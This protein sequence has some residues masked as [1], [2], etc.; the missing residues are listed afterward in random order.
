LW[1]LKALNDI[2]MDMKTTLLLFSTLA[3][4]V[5]CLCCAG[6]SDG[7]GTSHRARA[8]IP[9][10][11]C[12][13][14]MDTLYAELDNPWGMAWLPDN[15]LLVTEREGA[16]LVFENDRYTNEQLEGFPETYVHGQ[17][18]LLDIQPHPNYAANG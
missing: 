1:H 13:F 12:T 17:G 8:P 16:I 14:Y 2:V 18:G 10:E 4:G 6:N 3:S 15:K 5:C 9:S 7:H 11:K